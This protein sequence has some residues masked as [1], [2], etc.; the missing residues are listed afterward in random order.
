MSLGEQTLQISA[1]SSQ[2]EAASVLRGSTQHPPR[3]K[4]LQSSVAL[5]NAQEPTG[6]EKQDSA[7]SLQDQQ[8][9]C[10]NHGLYNPGCA[11]RGSSYNMQT[12]IICIY[13]PQ[14][15]NEPLEKLSGHV[16]QSHWWASMRPCFWETTGLG[17]NPVKITV[18]EC[19]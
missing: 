9:V 6:S 13:T 3:T 8:H 19:V 4:R 11:H 18:R 14:G 5:L 10:V 16:P 1:H 15:T 12:K 2:R 17:S 7:R